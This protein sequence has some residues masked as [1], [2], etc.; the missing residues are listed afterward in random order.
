MSHLR[1]F[2]EIGIDDVPL[3]GGKNASLGEMY[4]RL[5]DRDIRVPD[6]FAVTADGYRHFL[7]ESGIGSS[8]VTVFADLDVDDRKNLAER[9]ARARGL[10]LDGELPRD[11]AEEIVAGYQALQQEY[12]HDVALAVRSSATAEDLPDASFAGQHE[13]FLH[14]Q[15][16][17]AL[18]DA[19]RRCFASLFTDRA[20]D[21]RARHGYDQLSVALSVG[22]MKMVRSDLACSGVTFTLDTESGFRD[23][24][25][26]TGSYGLGENVV[27]GLVE[28]DEFYVHKPTYAA[29]HRAVLSRH[30][31]SKAVRMVL[32]E[33][34]PVREE[35]TPPRDRGRFC[36]SDEEVL[37]LA[38][39]A[40]TIERHYGRPMDIEWAKDGTDGLLYV[41]QARP[42]TVAARRRPAATT[43]YVVEAHGDLL[44]T[45]R[46]VGAKVAAGPARIVRG[47]GEDEGFMPGDVLVAPSTSP[48]WEP[49]MKIASA[50]V[51][52]HG[53]RT[54]H[55]A[56]VARE[57]GIP[58]VVG[59]GDATRT[60][61]DDELVT[62]SCAEGDDGRV[63]RGRADF[64]T[65][66]VAG[67]MTA[68]PRTHV[69]L[70]L[71]NPG[72][73]FESSFLP[74]DGVGLARMEF[75][76]AEHVRV[77][78]IA[79]LH[80]ERIADA[81][82]RAEVE[83]LVGGDGA[84][85]VVERLAE[86][87]GTI[88]AA[89]H[90]KPVV[91]RLS[92]FKTNEY[93]ALLGGAAF[94]PA[95]ANPMLGFRGAARYAHP[96]Y[97][98]GFALECAALRRVRETMGLENVVVM[99]PFVRRLDEADR[100]LARMAE[101]GLR[102][103]EHGLKVYAMCEIPAN[104]ILVDDFAQRFDGFS[105]GSNDL[106]QLTL[107]VDRDSELVDFDYDERDPAV[108]RM[109]RLAVEGCRRNGIHSGI[110][111]Q[112]PSDHPE[113][114]RALV[115]LGIDSISVTPDSVLA[116]TRTVLAAEG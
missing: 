72:I 97:T 46:A 61:T 79:A 37:E 102:R 51:T 13:T 9:S 19:V 34:E 115:G 87:I 85:Y 29:G 18:L 67:D 22:V 25:F 75:V 70:N 35:P 109:I 103:G 113:V 63:Y 93:A 42:E 57:L 40:M 82:Q 47:A 84:A 64:R 83:R 43:R 98:E 73:A 7:G 88:A 78:P 77:H 33:T 71:G 53:G 108:Q 17:E 58:A 24:V 86:G 2:A 20:V 76:L 10:L 116:V 21:Y 68:R 65:I 55:A 80:P 110:C 112:A 3:V 89:F 74:N 5:R 32:G 66:E 52:E 104:V 44:T 100:V 81:R 30:L 12:G 54:C 69:M 38:G 105:I 6:G 28:P 15:D 96:A 36:L 62:V 91:V 4:R 59:T 99:V 27:Q 39:S 1:T 26:V 23:V 107:G 92:D 111:G 94:E 45:G 11:L 101:L 56:I 90:P 31:G 50:V 14:V 41:V 95:E 106:T 60:I 49:L 48:D 16:E 114:V 8:L